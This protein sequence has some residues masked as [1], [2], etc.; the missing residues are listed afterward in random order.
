MKTHTIA[1]RI[2]STLKRSGVDLNKIQHKYNE[3]RDKTKEDTSCWPVRIENFHLFP[4]DVAITFLRIFVYN[5]L[6]KAKYAQEILGHC[7]FNLMCDTEDNN[8]MYDYYMQFCKDCHE[9][10]EDK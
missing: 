8:M 9:Q 3:Y 1:M 10:E 7:L 5:N 6:I 2:Y 4:V